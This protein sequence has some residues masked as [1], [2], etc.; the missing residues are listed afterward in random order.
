[1]KKGCKTCNMIWS[2]FFKRIHTYVDDQKETDLRSTQWS[3]DCETRGDFSLSSYTFLVSKFSTVVTLLFSE[4]PPG[5]GYIQKEDNS[6]LARY[7]PPKFCS[8]VC[9]CVGCD[10]PL[11][12][13]AG[14]AFYGKAAPRWEG[15]P[16]DLTSCSPHLLH[17]GAGAACLIHFF[18]VPLALMSLSDWLRFCFTSCPTTP[19]A[20][21][22]IETLNICWSP[23][24][25]SFHTG[26]TVWLSD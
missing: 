21:S 8:K 13:V 10:L 14:P 24:M 25:K 17:H 1:M 19:S 20:A 16:Q 22:Y 6:L 2:L 12:F 4:K 5:N 3:T 9:D 23:R 11:P 18:S 15:R 26:D 7:C